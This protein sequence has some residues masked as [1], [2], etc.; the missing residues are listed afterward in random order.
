MATKSE[1]RAEAPWRVQVRASCYRRRRGL[2]SA[3]CGVE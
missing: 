1:G 3:V 2:V